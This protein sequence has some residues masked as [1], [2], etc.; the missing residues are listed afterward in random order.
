MLSAVVL[1]VWL[2]DLG[3]CVVDTVCGGALAQAGGA[4]LAVQRCDLVAEPL[5]VV[6]KLA[7][8]VVSEGEAL[9]QRGVG[10]RRRDRRGGG[11]RAAEGSDLVAE[12]GLGV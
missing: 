10:C 4:E 7:D 2:A 5:V 9:P 11:C 6:G 12:F 3:V 1:S 8:A